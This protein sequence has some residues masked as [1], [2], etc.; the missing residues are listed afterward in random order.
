MDGVAASLILLQL[1]GIQLTNTLRL[2]TFG[3]VCNLCNPSA[4]GCDPVNKYFEVL[5]PLDGLATSVA[6]GWDPVNKYFEDKNLWMG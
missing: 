4:A 6:A 3:W 2:K 5:K 1:G